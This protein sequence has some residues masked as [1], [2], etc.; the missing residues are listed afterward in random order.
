M[1]DNQAKC[2]Q[3]DTEY[4]V[5]GV[6]PEAHYTLDCTVYHAHPKHAGKYYDPQ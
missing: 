2:T 5:R 6:H 1:K 4:H 3:Q